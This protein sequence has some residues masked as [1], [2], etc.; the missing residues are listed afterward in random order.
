M[1]TSEEIRVVVLQV[2]A[3]LGI[4]DRMLSQREAERQ[5]GRWF[6]DAVA[7][8]DLRPA[9]TGKRTRWYSLAE[10]KAYEARQ[11]TRA[12]LQLNEIKHYNAL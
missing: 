8:G 12:R 6:R 3:E 10:I 5:F 11:R 9:R 4:A 7:R 2:L 1:N